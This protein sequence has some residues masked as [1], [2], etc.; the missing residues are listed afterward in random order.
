VRVLV[1]GGV[2]FIGSHVVDRLVGDGYDVVVL[3]CSSPEDHSYVNP[4]A[5]YRILDCT[6]DAAVAEA[7]KDI[8]AVSHQAAMVGLETSPRDMVNYVR[9][10]CLGTATLLQALY[11][12]DFRGPLV[13]A[14]SMVV[15]GEGAFECS[16][17]G[18]V[19]PEPRT[20]ER[21]ERSLFEPECPTCGSELAPVAVSEHD[22]TDPRSVYAATKLHQEHLCFAFGR[23]TGNPVTA[24]RYHNVYGSRMARA[25]PYAGVAALFVSRLD[26]GKAPLVFEDGRQLRDFIHVSDVANANTLALGARRHGAFNIATGETHSVRDIADALC[27]SFGTESPTPE[28]TGRFRLGDVRHIFASPNRALNELGFTA[29]VTFGEGMA[30]FARSTSATGAAD[31]AVL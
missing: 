13:L 19:R 8:D 23:E 26:E 17:D 3:D 1:T 24:L 2:G 9:N 27:D 30:A 25:T 15:Y 11:E 12:S 18:P 5:D 22:A 7:V 6:D 20:R 10:N 31:E 28:L 29:D 16:V 14:S 4:R 21:L